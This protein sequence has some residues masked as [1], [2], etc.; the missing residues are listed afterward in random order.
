MSNTIALHKDLIE[1]E[2]Q[3]QAL[4]PENSTDLATIESIAQT[5]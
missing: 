2:L 3:D 4:I 5:D 1:K